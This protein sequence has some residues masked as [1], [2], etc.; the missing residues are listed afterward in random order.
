MKEE[1]KLKP[2]RAW[3]EIDLAHLEHNIN[4]IKKIISP[5]TKI[6]AVVKANAYGHD[7]VLI[8]QKLN[9][10]GITDFAVATFEEG[11]NL[12]NNNIKG[13]ILIL[14][15]TPLTEIEEVIKYDLN[16]TIV[17]EDYALKINELSLSSKI[18]CSI[19][20][21]TGM[22][23]L[24]ISYQNIAAIKRIYTYKNLNILGIH[25]HLC[26]ADSL[27]NKDIKFTYNQISRFNNVI[28]E[29]LKSHIKVG[30]T[31]LQSSYG[32]LNYPGI[33]YDY[34]RP[35]LILFGIN[36]DDH[37][38]PKTKLDL[39]PVYYLKSR[40]TSIKEINPN[41]YVGYGRHFKACKKTKIATVSIG[42]GDAYPR[43]LSNRHAYVL[44][45]NKYAPVIGNICMD[46]LIID[47]TDIS[48]V[49]VFDIVT[50]IGDEKLIRAEHVA[51][52]ANTITNELLCA[53]RD[54]LE[55]IIKD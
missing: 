11:K 39:K 25:S 24:G 15:Y 32:I 28:L 27:K 52:L 23:R 12:R 29:L 1:T 36:S 40:I 16:I 43:I 10:I 55:Y 14:G 34:V 20:I 47:V 33:T 46:Q 38:K 31:H 6:M 26:C 42:Y 19:K 53:R 7:A 44:V 3:V 50:L 45:N 49:N 35:G 21:N 48:D 30:K 17:D 5:K 18:N 41:E 51:T 4:E 22:N 8:S 54:R 2:Y 9:E 13:N 37:T